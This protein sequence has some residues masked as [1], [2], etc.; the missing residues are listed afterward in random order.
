MTT[1]AVQARDIFR[2]HTAGTESFSFE[3]DTN[4]DDSLRSILD[5]SLLKNLVKGSINSS[6]P[7]QDRNDYINNE[8]I[9]K[10]DNSL[11]STTSTNTTTTSCYYDNEVDNSYV[12]FDNEECDELIYYFRIHQYGTFIHN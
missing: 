9:P 3:N 4:H 10:V 6:K 2:A 7:I 1:T 5:V 12:K 11:K 8:T